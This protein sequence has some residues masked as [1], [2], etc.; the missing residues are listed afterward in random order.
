MGTS[1]KASSDVTFLLLQMLLL[2]LLLPFQTLF[3]PN[4]GTAQAHSAFFYYSCQ[5]NVHSNALQSCL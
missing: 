5:Y 1:R 3:T 2:N 4:N